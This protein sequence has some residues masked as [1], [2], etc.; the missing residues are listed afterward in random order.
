MFRKGDAIVAAA[1]IVIAGIFFLFVL[2]EEPGDTVVVRQDGEIVY[3]GPLERDYEITLQ[4][5]YENMIVIRD[6]SVWYEQS[7]CPGKDCVRSG[8]I[9]SGGQSAACL[10][11]RT[12]VSVTSREGGVDVVVR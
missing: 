6:G 12:S 3:E 11:N 5:D 7:N 10:P 9:T 1:L 8:K 2:F 4:G